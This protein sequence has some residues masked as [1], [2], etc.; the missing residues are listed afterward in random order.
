[1]ASTCPDNLVGIVDQSLHQVKDNTEQFEKK[2]EKIEKIALEN[3]TELEILGKKIDEVL[4][5][6]LKIKPVDV[7]ALEDFINS[8]KTAF[9]KLENIT[10]IHADTG[11]AVAAGNEKAQVNAITEVLHDSQNI[12]AKLNEVASATVDIKDDIKSDSIAM[13]EA[14]VKIS[15][16]TSSIQPCGTY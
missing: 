8:G 2:I 12:F 11:N 13:K 4:A 7:D 6:Q 16:D 5:H 3:K 15:K 10:S 1:M 14:V 9:T